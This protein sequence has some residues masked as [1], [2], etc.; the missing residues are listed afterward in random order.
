[1]IGLAWFVVLVMVL[2]ILLVAGFIAI[3]GLVNAAHYLSG[4]GRRLSHPR[5]GANPAGG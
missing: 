5:T 3:A 2:A 1:M 4:F